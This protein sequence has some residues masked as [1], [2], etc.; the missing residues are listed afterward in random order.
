MFAAFFMAT[1]M[2]TSPVTPVGEIIFGAGCGMLT[3]MIRQYTPYPEGVTFAVLIMNALTPAIESL[4]IP[5]V[6]GVGESYKTRIR[7]FAITAAAVL[8][9]FAGLVIGV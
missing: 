3:F 8:V 2:V 1:D 7:G 5:P 9:I 6:F 4:T